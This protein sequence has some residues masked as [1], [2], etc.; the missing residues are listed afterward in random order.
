MFKNEPYSCFSDL[1]DSLNSLNSMKVPL[2]LGKTPIILSI[3]CP[4]TDVTHKCRNQH[5]GCIAPQVTAHFNK[6]N[7]ISTELEN[8][9]AAWYNFKS[10]F[11]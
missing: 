3:S 7:R 1:S 4:L 11:F 2:H 6:M 10:L 9:K 8:L 5:S